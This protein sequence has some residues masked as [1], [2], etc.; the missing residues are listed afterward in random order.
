MCSE[1]LLYLDLYFI[2]MRSDVQFYASLRMLAHLEELR[3]RRTGQVERDLD[4]LSSTLPDLINLKNLMVSDTFATPASLVLALPEGL[5][6]AVFGIYED[7][8]VAINDLTSRLEGQ[9]SLLTLPPELL[10]RIFGFIIDRPYTADPS[11]QVS[12]DG[13]ALFQ[14]IDLTGPGVVALVFALHSRPELAS[15][16][17]AAVFD[18]EMD[19]IESFRHF[20]FLCEAALRALRHC[21]NLQHLAIGFVTSD[22]RDNLV[23]LLDTL[24]LK[25]LVLTED[26]SWSALHMD[27][28]T[29]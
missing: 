23:D 28:L 10:A 25:T 18:V 20:D 13:H 11:V 21:V 6:I 19:D 3:I 14:S 2:D 7:L 9:V 5:K 27:R 12:I 15:A 29:R 16:T 8:P 1:T 22:L 24:P 4:P 26:S 17:R